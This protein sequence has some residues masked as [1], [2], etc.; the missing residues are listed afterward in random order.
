MNKHTIA[1]IGGTGKSGTY[2]LNN[3]LQQGYVVRLL[4]RN[5]A[6]FRRQHPLLEIV[7]GDVRRP[8]DLLTLL[9]P[10]A[11]LISTLGQPKGEPSVF[12]QATQNCLMAMRE[13]GI[14][15]Y[16]VTTG[17]SVNTPFDQKDQKVQAATAWMY[18]HYPETTADKQKEYEWLVTSGS[19][20]D[21]T[22]VRLPLIALTSNS[23]PVATSLYN[24]PG[25]GISATDLASFLVQ[26]LSDKQY[27]RQ[28][29][30]LANV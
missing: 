23:S 29:P 27:L 3:L 22:L 13:T 25:D 17:L 26:Q 18:Q 20:I 30:F 10:C 15:R 28:S 24:C 11:A 4:L 12:S 5:P 19:D 1:L 9:K 16:I 21:W 8:T 2:V 14:S 6:S 7:S